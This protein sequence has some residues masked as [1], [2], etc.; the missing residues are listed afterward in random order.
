MGLYGSP[1]E[2]DPLIGQSAK[3][4]AETSKEYLEWYKKV[5]ADEISPRQRRNDDLTE[6]L[7]SDYLDT[8][9]QNKRMASEQLARQKALFYPVEEKMV[10]EAMN[11]DSPERMERMAGQAAA[12]VNQQFSNSRNQ[13]QRSLGAYGLRPDS[14][15]FASVN[16]KLALGQA[17]GTAA[18]QNKART[19][20]QDKAI[21]LRAGAANFG[22]GLG[23]QAAGGFSTSIAANQ[24][25]GGQSAQ[26]INSAMQGYAGMGNA[27]NT[28][29]SGFGQAG[30]LAY[31][32]TMA[33]LQSFNAEMA[34]MNALMSAAGT[35][36]GMY[37]GRTASS[38]SMK[39]DKK[40]VREGSAL[41]GVNNLDVESWSYKD[42]PERESHIGPYA[43]DFKREFGVGDGKTINVVD[44]LG[45]TM[46]AIQDL[47]DRVEK[48]APQKK[49]NGGAIKSHRGA[50]PVRG[51][52]GPVGD[53]I[54]AM[55]SNGEYVLPADTV[56]AIGKNKLDKIVDKTHTPAAIQRSRAALKKG[57]K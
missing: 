41:K 47:S 24:G 4:S 19:D 57:R 16:T 48:L 46:K 6:S 2:T 30:S 53:K 31:Q 37:A 1:P 10:Q 5:Y 35:A 33:G 38:K 9:S 11:Y 21:A 42:D 18:A 20:V 44:A 28:A 54:P 52:G 55:L 14:G 17:L 36:A 43:E 29:M 40:E 34:P 7:V 32:N 26:N 23:S 3:L 56:K 8:S 45:V 12:D 13:M 15:A 22:R 49:A 51:P 39:T 50:G 27:Y 25:A